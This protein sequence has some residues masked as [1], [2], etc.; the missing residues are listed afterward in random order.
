[1]LRLPPSGLKPAAT[2]IASTSVDLPLPFSPANSV[3]AESSLSSS[4]WRIAGIENGYSS[5]LSTSPRFRTSERTKRSSGRRGLFGIQPQRLA[6]V[7]TS[8]HGTP[9]GARAPLQQGGAERRLLVDG[10]G[11][12]RRCRDGRR[13]R[14]AGPFRRP[15]CGRG[16]IPRP[17]APRR[18]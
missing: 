7:L 12:H 14:P 18:G 11:G 15:A 1:M 13:G 10:G 17:A 6:A 3:T 9:R 8:R 2:A 16:R 4:R 5:K